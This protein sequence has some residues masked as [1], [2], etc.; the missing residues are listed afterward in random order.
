MPASASLA[1][2]SPPP[3]FAFDAVAFDTCDLVWNPEVDLCAVNS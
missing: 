2:G 1:D 3:L